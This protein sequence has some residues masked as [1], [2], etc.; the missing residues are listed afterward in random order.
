MLATAKVFMTGNSQ[1]IRLPKPFRVNVSEVWITKNDA[2]GEITLKPKPERD[3][4]EAFFAQLRAMPV[5]D[6]FLLPRD[7]AYSPDPFEGWAE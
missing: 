5:T 7:D 6:E 4:L 1:A 2:T 3:D